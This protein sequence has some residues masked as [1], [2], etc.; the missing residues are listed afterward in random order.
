MGK[1]EK[2]AL[3]AN[4]EKSG[5]AMQGL[6]EINCNDG[7]MKI[8]IVGQ[9]LIGSGTNK[10]TVYRIKGHD[11]LGEIDVTRRFKEFFLFREIMF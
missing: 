4:F 5:G 1:T 6:D 7:K 9:E 3:V 11:S 10:H 8:D 2:D